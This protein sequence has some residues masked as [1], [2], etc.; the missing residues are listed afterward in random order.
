MENCVTTQ[1]DQKA[2]LHHN[3]SIID[4]TYQ[5]TSNYYS[6]EAI[7]NI[8]KYTCI[9]NNLISSYKN[10]SNKPFPPCQDQTLDNKYKN[11][12]DPCLI[13]TYNIFHKT[14]SMLCAYFV[15]PYKRQAFY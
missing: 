2:V 15:S 14:F 5:I 11:D 7:N 3:N 10:K 4:N 13:W 9:L 8:K 6:I 12:T 1:N